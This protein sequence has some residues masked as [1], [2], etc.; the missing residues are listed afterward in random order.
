[1]SSRSIS[2]TASAKTSS[3]TWQGVGAVRDRAQHRVHIQGQERRCV[4]GRAAA[5]RQPCA[6]RQRA[7]G[8]WPCAHHRA[9]DRWR[10]GGHV[11]AERYDRDLTDIF[12]LQDEISEADRQGAEAEVVAAREERSSGGERTISRLTTCICEGRARRSRPTKSVLASLCSRRRPGWR[13]TMP[14]RGARWRKR[15][16][17]G[18]IH[19]PMPS[20]MKYAGCYAEAERALALDPHNIAAMAAQF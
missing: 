2:A 16:R 8:G 11:W 12:A 6:R 14:M 1:M 18:G 5:Q 13:P 4:T 15:V 10:H 19:R 17:S 9:A 20:A 3:P 7:Q